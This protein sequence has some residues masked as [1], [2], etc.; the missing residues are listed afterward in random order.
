MTDKYFTNSIN[1]LL[2]TLENLT[3]KQEETRK[4]I[5]N[6]K[7]AVLK[8]KRTLNN[9][10]QSKDNTD[11][12]VNGS[13]LQL[14][15]RVRIVNPSAGQQNEGEIVGKTKRQPDKIKNGQQKRGEKNT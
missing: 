6:T 11:L 3:I 8:L 4:E 12:I 14:K 2:T 9:K 15:D 5:E 13:D 1:E 7:T 10:T